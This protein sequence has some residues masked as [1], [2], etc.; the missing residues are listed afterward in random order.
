MQRNLN[1]IFEIQF[2]FIGCQCVSEAIERLL[3][4]GLQISEGR[5][6]FVN[7]GLVQQA[8]RSVNEQ[9]NVFMKFDVRRK[10]HLFLCHVSSTAE[11]RRQPLQRPHRGIARPLMVMIVSYIAR[12]PVLNLARRVRIRVRDRVAFAVLVPRALDLV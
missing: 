7:D 2:N 11:F 3:E 12:I 10:F 1:D 5:D 6:N 9:T 4:F 8:A